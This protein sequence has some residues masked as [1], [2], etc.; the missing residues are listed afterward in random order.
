MRAIAGAEDG[1]TIVKVLSPAAFNI[2]QERALAQYG[3]PSAKLP[4]R[5]VAAGP[6]PPIY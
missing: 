4:S 2:R 5:S 3:P 6:H 1:Q